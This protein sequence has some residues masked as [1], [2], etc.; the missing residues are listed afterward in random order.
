MTCT[1]TVGSFLESLQKGRPWL[2]PLLGCFPP[3]CYFH[4]FLY[5]NP[6]FCC[7]VFPFRHLIAFFYTPLDFLHTLFLFVVLDALGAHV[8]FGPAAEGGGAQSAKR[9]SAMA[10]LV[11]RFLPIVEA[12]FVAN[13]RDPKGADKPLEEEVQAH[14]V[15]RYMS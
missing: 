13:A 7:H 12:F 1:H 5:G 15:L 9:T 14:A 11:A 6:H 10:G 2:A 3:T 8:F 4:L